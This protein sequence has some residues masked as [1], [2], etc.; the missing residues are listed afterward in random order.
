VYKW[1]GNVFAAY[2]I[3]PTQGAASCEF[4]TVGG[5]SFLA[6]ANSRNDATA[7]VASTLYKWNGGRFVETLSIPTYG[8]SDLAFFTVDGVSFLAAANSG[9]DA[10]Q[11]VVSMIYQYDP[12]S[13]E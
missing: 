4:Y 1:D 5:D 12:A 3:L 8:A 11:G 7:E 6:V 9:D 10:A 13:A 2:Q